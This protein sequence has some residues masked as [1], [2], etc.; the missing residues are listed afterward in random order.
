[1]RTGPSQVQTLH[2][3]F[4][5]PVAVLC[6]FFF[7]FFFHAVKKS[8]RMNR[9]HRWWTTVMTSPSL[10]HWNPPPP[11]KKTRFLQMWHRRIGLGFIIAA[12]YWK[13]YQTFDLLRSSFICS[14]FRE[15]SAR[16]LGCLHWKSDHHN[17]W[18]GLLQYHLTLITLPDTRPHTFS[19]TYWN[20]LFTS[21]CPV[22]EQKR[23]IAFDLT[24]PFTL[25]TISLHLR[26]DPLC[27]CIDIH[28]IFLPSQQIKSIIRLYSLNPDHQ[29]PKMSEDRRWWS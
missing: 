11:T 16:S 23:T 8:Q 6:V 10:I 4:N 25:F 15:P 24:A 13:E 28:I 1:M 27:N 9:W 7:L 17:S 18:M 19:S 20:F 3:R 29:L 26:L 22:S 2:R 14:A 12:Y 5:N 21:A